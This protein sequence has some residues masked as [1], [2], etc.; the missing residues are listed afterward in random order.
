MTSRVMLRVLTSTTKEAPASEYD[1][2]QFVGIDLHQRGSVI[3]RRTD[4]GQR[5]ETVRIVNDV[6]RFAPVLAR[7]GQT[8][9]VVLEPRTGGTGRRTRRPSWVLR[10]TWRTRWR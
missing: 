8:P 3:V 1:G 5:L 7:A 2:Q 9:Q 10:C 6:D 4:T